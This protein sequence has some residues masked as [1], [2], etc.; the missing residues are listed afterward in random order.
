MMEIE[1]PPAPDFLKQKSKQ[2]TDNFINRLQNNS[3]AKFY[4]PEYNRKKINKLLMPELEKMTKNHCSFCDACDLGASSQQTIE[5]FKPKS[6]YPENAYAWENLFL[7]CNACQGF[8]KEE[9]SKNLLKPDTGDYS[10][11]RYFICDYNNGK[12]KPNPVA[13]EEDKERAE[14]TIKLY[15]LNEKG[16]PQIR[17]RAF[18]YYS[19][20]LS[21]NKDNPEISNEE[22]L[23]FNKRPY[24][25]FL[26]NCIDYKPSID[27]KNSIVITESCNQYQN[28]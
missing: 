14:I 11:K 10:F 6:I 25:F 12:L 4:W 27:L 28:R 7:C 3:D 13:A 15:G 17:L 16:R 22:D 24:R 8:K 21:T 23:D 26:M 19:S 1:R 2:W 20:I 18:K 9:Y 5:H